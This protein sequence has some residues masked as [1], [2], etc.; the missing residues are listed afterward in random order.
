MHVRRPPSFLATKKKPARRRGGGR[1]DETLLES[2]QDVLLHRLGFNHRQRVD[3]AVWRCKACKQVDGTVPG[4]M[5]R[6]TGGTGLGENLPEIRVYLC[7]IGLEG[8]H[9]TLNRRGTTG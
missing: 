1:A 5:R 9:R 4:A 6:E 3:A 8:N 2:L 7:D